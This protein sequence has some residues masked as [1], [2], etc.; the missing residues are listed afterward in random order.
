MNQNNNNN[1]KL[2]TR[3]PTYYMQ[4]NTTTTPPIP[5]YLIVVFLC[6]YSLCMVA[7]ARTH[8]VSC[9]HCP[10]ARHFFPNTSKFLLLSLYLSF[11]LIYLFSV[12]LNTFHPMSYPALSIF[13]IYKSFTATTTTTTTT[14][15]RYVAPFTKHCTR[16]FTS[17]HLYTAHLKPIRVYIIKHIHTRSDSKRQS[18][19]AAEHSSTSL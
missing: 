15:V 3:W 11:S 16:S 6:C 8:T 18:M 19:S 9:V 7:L 2:W 17:T 1:L 5:M 10:F 13:A 12:S 4:L 14:T